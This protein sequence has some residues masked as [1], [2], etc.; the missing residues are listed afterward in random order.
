TG[1]G[2]GSSGSGC[3]TRT[4]TDSVCVVA[5]VAGD[6]VGVA[7]VVAVVTA[8]RLG[9]G[10]GG[11]CR[12][13]T[14]VDGP[15]DTGPSGSVAVMVSSSDVHVAPMVRD[16]VVRAWA[17]STPGSGARS[18]GSSETASPAVRTL[19]ISANRSVS[20]C[21]DEVA[22]REPATVTVR[23]WATVAG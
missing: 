8:G 4:R 15:T 18:C 11:S 12:Q 22:M 21:S 6:A 5:C 10:R 19:P 3:C 14:T 13:P 16:N 7:V 20:A 9:F 2:F 23:A 17:G 1:T